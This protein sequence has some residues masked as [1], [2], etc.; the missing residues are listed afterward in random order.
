MVYTK[1]TKGNHF[2]RPHSHPNDRYIVVL[3]GTWW[4]GSGP[5]RD[6]NATTPVKA[7]GFV[8]H[9]P[10]KIHWDGAKDEEVIVQIMG[11]GPSATIR[12]DESGQPKK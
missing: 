9:Y 2:S 5:V 12:V 3:Q 6:L 8:V 10:N 7:G 11:V 4:V 1:W